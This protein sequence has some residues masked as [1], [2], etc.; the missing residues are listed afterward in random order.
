MVVS[1][2]LLTPRATASTSAVTTQL[3]R[4]LDTW[5]GPGILVIAGNLF[6]LTGS[7]SLLSGCLGSLEAHPALAHS[8]ERFLSVG[9]R[10]VIRQTGTHEVG[11]DT[12]PETTAAVAARGVEQLGPVDLHCQTATGVRVVRVE[13]GAHAYTIGCSGPE[14]EFDPAA[15]AKPGV[16]GH[17]SAGKG[18]RTLAAQSTDDAPWLVGLDR[19]SD[20]SALSRFVVSR[21]LYRR[22]GRYAWWLLVPFVVAALL[23]VAVTPWVLDHLG[24]G[25]PARALRHAH[26]ADLGDQA[27]IALLVAVV[28]L[29]VL[30]L[31]LGLLSR[32]MWSILGGGT[33]DAVRTQADAND[34]ARDAARELVGQGYT[35]VITAATFQSELT[36]LGVGFYANV[37]A[38]AEV[39]E[40]H[41]GRLG[42]PPVFTHNQRVSWVEL[43][44]GAEL[45]VRMLLTAT[46]S[47]RRA[48]SSGW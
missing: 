30:A 48:R 29:G 21:T 45:H 1:D 9:E 10:R 38:T 33:L 40:E 23:R 31:V 27:V 47:A 26:Q 22:L 5:D 34:T 43:E 17:S 44:T 3:A 46:I 39:V 13:P 8:L 11:I 25:L 6:D 16:I 42:L 32:R 12:D 36:H 28:V 41:R 7:A 14:T 19:L 18:W 2:L 24:S 4:A 15:D 37:G 35:G 20:P